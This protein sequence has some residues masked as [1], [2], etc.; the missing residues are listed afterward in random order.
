MLI[1][2]NIKEKEIKKIM[3]ETLLKPF[4]PEVDKLIRKGLYNWDHG[5]NG[6]FRMSTSPRLKSGACKSSS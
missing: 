5:N 6:G 1:R 3:N 2:K 4:S